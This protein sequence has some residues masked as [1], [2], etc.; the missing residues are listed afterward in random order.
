M[1]T[2]T[3]GSEG[4]ARLCPRIAVCFLFVTLAGCDQR[5]RLHA[6]HDRAEIVSSDHY[7]SLYENWQRAVEKMP[8]YSKSTPYTDLPEFADIVASGRGIVPL[9]REKIR[10]GKDIDI[11]LSLAVI[12]IMGWSEER[13]SNQDLTELTRQVLEELD[14]E[15]VRSRLF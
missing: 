6:T 2:R 8:P 7:I 9:L 14:R 1:S 4:H 11:M 3:E 10:N 13:F 12:K 15:A 5:P